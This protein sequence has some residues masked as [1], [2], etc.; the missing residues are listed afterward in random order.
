ME[1]VMRNTR[2]TIRIIIAILGL[3]TLGALG[4]WALHSLL[5]PPTPSETPAAYAIVTAEN[6]TLERS[7]TLSAAAQRSTET[8]LSAQL[9]G[10]LTSLDAT[11]EEPQH[12][13][14]LLYTVDMQPVVLA[15]GNIPAYRELS[16]GMR[17]P[18]IAQLQRFLNTVRGYGLVP[19]GNFGSRTTTAILK[20]NKKLGFDD[21]ESV[22]LGRLVFTPHIPVA[23]T[24]EKDIE[25]GAPIHSGDSIAKTLQSEPR[26]TMTIPTGQLTLISQGMLA[27]ITMGT[28]SWNAQIGPII[29][30]QETS[31]AKATLL[32]L[33]GEE[34]ICHQEC[35]LI[36]AE[37]SKGLLTR[38]TIVPDAS[39]VIVPTA[40]L[41]VDANSNTVLMSESGEFIDVEVVTSTQGR[42]IVNGINV[43][44]RIRVF[45][46]TTPGSTHSSTQNVDSSES[47]R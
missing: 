22:P 32:P 42:S 37:G 12:I 21:Q 2:S 38:V 40:A 33:Q 11:Q 25:V 1:L 31:D 24:W 36:P 14:D 45:A 20:W 23:L 7:L 3:L 13:G 18:D 26:F 28:T 16:E 47:V 35:S 46:T 43:G 10:T 5:A 4:G 29:I 30:D 34:S 17:G 41:R 19:D 27:S 44:T 9:S 39:G 15:E 6:G 8:T